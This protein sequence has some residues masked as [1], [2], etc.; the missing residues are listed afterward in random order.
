VYGGG[1]NALAEKAVIISCDDYRKLVKPKESFIK[2]LYMPI[3]DDEDEDLFVRDKS[4]IGRGTPIE[5]SD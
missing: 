4:P 5:L 2:S 3:L 1:M